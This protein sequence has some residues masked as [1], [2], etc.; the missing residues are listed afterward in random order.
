MRLDNFMSQRS[1][2]VALAALIITLIPMAVNAIAPLRVEAQRV[3]M[4]ES[5]LRVRE[6]LDTP[7]IEQ[8]L[9]QPTVVSSAVS[10]APPWSEF[11]PAQT[12]VQV[13]PSNYD[14][15][16]A[17][18][19][20]GNPLTNEIILVLHETV[21]SASSAINTFQRSHTSDNDQ[22]SYHTM[23]T[24]DGTVV[25]LVPPEFRAFGAGNSVFNG[26][27][28]AETV[29]LDPVLPPSV[30]NFAYHTSLETPADGRGNGRR[31]SGYTEA[32]Y[33][34][35]A[36]LIAQTNIRE[37]RIT[38]HQAVDRSGTRLDPRSFDG[39]HFLSLLHAY[40][41]ES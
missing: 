26:P 3:E 23:I 9:P 29:R 7:T 12:I 37:E 25:Y 24:L 8:Q 36:W 1:I 28:G 2:V 11:V 31:H 14:Y 38:T 30:N 20:H 22:V 40:R 6:S 41:G 39:A 16:M 15:R 4:D 5:D 34:S 27:N 32:Q 21:N 13:D 18:D 19:I 33:R 17:T 35:L 10:G